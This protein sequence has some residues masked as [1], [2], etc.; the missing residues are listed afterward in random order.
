MLRQVEHLKKR[1]E[2]PPA[3]SAI[4]LSDPLPVYLEAVG[5]VTS[6][7]A[8]TTY[9]ESGFWTS[10]DVNVLDANRAMLRRIKQASVTAR[11]LILIGRPVADESD[12]PAYAQGVGSGPMTPTT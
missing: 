5:Q 9:L 7:F 8:T 11:R 12:H 4:S 6:E 1:L 10:R 3:N 2:S